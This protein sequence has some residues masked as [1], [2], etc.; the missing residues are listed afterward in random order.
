MK[1]SPKTPDPQALDL[2]AFCRAG[3]VLEGEW[4]LAGLERLAPALAA[5]TDA[6]VRWRAAGEL[7]PVTG[8]APEPWLALQAEAEAPLQCQ[9]C[10]QPLAERLLIDRRFRFVATEE[11]AAEVDEDAEEDVLALPPRLDLRALLED[12]LILAL[13]LV[14]RHES[15]PN[16]LPL[17]ADDAPAEPEA[18]HPFAA[19]AALKKP[20]GPG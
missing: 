19:L 1:D 5:A 8:G 4:P 18:P 9:R 3:G 20:G 7:R 10:L 13:P 16:P 11:E 14:P 2:P 12:E 15:C 6:T 17:P